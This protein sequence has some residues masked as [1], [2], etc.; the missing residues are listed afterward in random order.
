MSEDRQ[1]TLHTPALSGE[2]ELLVLRLDA[3]EALSKLYEYDALLYARSDSVDFDQVLGK[4]MSIGLT[5]PPSKNERYFH[6]YVAGFASVGVQGDFSLY[7]AQI[8]PH[9]WRLTRAT[10]SRAFQNKTVPQI[11]EHVL[12][13]HGIANVEHHLGEG[14]RSP[15]LPWD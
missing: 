3:R 9:L 5:L 12:K 6:G 10:N 11:I 14:N 2:Q 13:E 7:R 4:E 8:R 1:L 15:Y